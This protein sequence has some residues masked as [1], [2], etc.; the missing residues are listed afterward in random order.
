M[1]SS[2]GN[3]IKVALI[4]CGY[5]GKNLARNFNDLGA[6][7][8]VADSDPANRAASEERLPNVPT[9]GDVDS[10]LADESIRAVAMATPAETHSDLAYKALQAGKHVYVEKPLCLDVQVGMELVRQAN[11]RG[12]T[13][14][15]GHLL[16]YHPA[17]QRLKQMVD[18]G[19]LGRLQ[20]IHSNRLNLGKVRR[21]ENILWSFAPHDISVILSLTG[22][23]PEDVSAMGGNY[24]QRQIADTTI[25]TMSFPSGVKAHIYVSW[26]YPYKEQRLVVIGSQA[27]VVFNDTHPTEKLRVYPH[28]ITYREG[29][30][31]VPEA[32][33]YKVV[34]FG[35]AEPLKNECNHFLECV[36]TGLT[37]IT[38]GHEGLRVLRVL[39]RCQQSLNMGGGYVRP[40]ISELGL[41]QQGAYSVHPTSVVD[42]GCQIGQGTKIWH[43]SH[44]LS[45]S[46]VGANCNLGQNVVVGPKAVIGD[47]CKIQNNVSVYQG[48][49]LGNH[50][51]C[52]PSMVFTN[53]LNPRSHV[54]RKHEY[55]DTVVGDGASFGANCTVVCGHNIGKYAF[56]G[57]G[58]V[59]V[60]DVPDYALMVGN[61]AVQ[62]G[63]MCACGVKLE[64]DDKG[65][66]ACAAC[67]EKYTLEGG[68]LRPL[69]E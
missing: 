13:L 45:G 42:A 26:L 62:K 33:D 39:D 49:H 2:V 47:G 8:V 51:F 34:D 65:R 57:A 30:V 53:V 36:A 43:F 40:G 10:V 6:L 68:K 48:V 41:E 21:E 25:S 5:W 60:K 56:I 9:T 24:L 59:V 63:W 14:M 27:M 28:R 19:Q 20:Y 52:G 69:A 4:G 38:D 32:S 15:V 11:E 44:I 18:E 54:S 50:V 66:A 23:M 35:Q 17:V 46:K 12:L 37:P 61:P 31:P 29:H 1:A 22:E 55:R 67:G 58:A 3:K 16:H 7:A 64:L